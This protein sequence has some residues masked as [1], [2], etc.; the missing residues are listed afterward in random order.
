MNTKQ[1]YYAVELSKSLNF[2]QVAERLGISQPALSK[3]IAALEKDLNIKLFDRTAPLSL[4]AA[5]EHFIR[6]AQELLYQEDQLM[7]S[8]EE[9]KT[10]DRGRL[11]I[12]ISPFRCLYL[13]PPV[14]K[15]LK[16][17]FPDIEIALHEISSDVLRQETAEG[18]YDFAI[19]NLPVDESVL[20][21]L[22]IEADTMVLAV[23]KTMLDAL[24]PVDLSEPMPQM[25]LKDCKNLP[26]ITV[27]QSQEMRRLFDQNCANAK[28][29]PHICMEVVG[30]ATAWAMA[31]EGLGATLLPLQ[32][33]N[34]MG[35][36][37]S[38]VLFTLKH[39]VRSRQPAV[40]TRR[41]QYLSKYAE[42]AIKLLTENT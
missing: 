7:R 15:K 17:E 36:H 30:V 20:D 40:C 12:G 37:E 33:V 18:K 16:E 10:G 28:F 22:P 19:I 13:I 24:P 23:P 26:F 9:Y 2:S 1:L 39:S 8:M 11:V 6:E 3:Q 38:L 32:F 35:D 41:G 21:V 42:Y 25:D 27:G 34:A 29:H 5:G 4:T 14:V 31:R